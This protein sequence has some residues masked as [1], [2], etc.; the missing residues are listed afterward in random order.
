MG[1]S[2][3]APYNVWGCTIVPAGHFG[4][5]SC[6]FAGFGNISAEVMESLSR[7]RRCGLSLSVKIFSRAIQ[8]TYL[9]ML[10]GILELFNVPCYN[11]NIGT[12]L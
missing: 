5:N 4:N 1:A 8:Q 3:D 11:D 7:R 2:C 10:D 12:L 9:D 6:C